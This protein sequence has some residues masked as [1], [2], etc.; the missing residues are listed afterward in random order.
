LLE[1]DRISI[2]AFKRK[3]RWS[4]MTLFQ[5][6]NIPERGITSIVGAGGKTS[7]CQQIAKELKHHG[8]RVLLTTTTAIYNPGNSFDVVIGEDFFS[9]TDSLK[10]KDDR[11]KAAAL[12]IL[13]GN[14][15][16][17][18]PPRWIDWFDSM[19]MFDNIIVE[20]D[21]ARGKSLKA[22]A[23]HEPQIPQRSA[24]TIVVMGADIFNEPIGHDNVHRC[25]ML[26]DLLGV[27]E[28]DIVTPELVYNVITTGE[29]LM[30]GIPK[31]SKRILA[32]NKVKNPAEEEFFDKLS[33]LCMEVRIFE[34]CFALDLHSESLLVKYR[35]EG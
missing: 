16:R 31:D 6:M 1:F 8:K 35:R 26:L 34:G 2:V 5:T 27:R 13:D 18:V 33:E 32:V 24:M 4:S 17:G 19:E 25:K 21:G 15:L 14:K 23:Y 22:Y 29:G 20:A 9:L 28:G 3:G 10:R 30:K 11:I 12:S 7:L